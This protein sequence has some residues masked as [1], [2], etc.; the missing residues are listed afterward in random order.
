MLAYLRARAFSRGFLGGSQ[1]WMAIGLVVWTIRLF[2]WLTRPEVDVVYR[3]RI[4]P[5]QAIQIRHLA[6]P[7]TGR[8]RRRAKRATRR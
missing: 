4:A 6:P 8:Q 2:Q 7:P 3:D 5:G 1:L